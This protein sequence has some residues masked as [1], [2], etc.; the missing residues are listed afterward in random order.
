MLDSYE[1]TVLLVSHDRDFLDRTVNSTIA[2]EGDGRVAEYPGGYSDYLH[3]RKELSGPASGRASRPAKPE[4]AAGQGG[5]V[6]LSYKETR[7]VDRKSGLGEKRVS[8]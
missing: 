3:Q 2:V 5:P 1:G 4:R 8:D 7:E 6:K